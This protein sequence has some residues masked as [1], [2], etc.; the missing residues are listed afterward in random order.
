MVFKKN[1]FSFLLLLIMVVRNHWEEGFWLECEG[2]ALCAWWHRELH[3]HPTALPRAVRAWPPSLQLMPLKL[4]YTPLQSCSYVYK[5]S[6]LW[7]MSSWR[8][9]Q[10][11]PLSKNPSSAMFINFP[12][13]G[14]ALHGIMSS[15]HFQI[16][17]YSV[18][19]R[20]FWKRFTLRSC[21]HWR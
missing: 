20:W 15:F 4:P 11:S 12:G 5:T 7:P 13:V 3:S 19:A 17:T 14:I 21:F 2:S 10:L 18:L 8:L 6:C 9:I 1:F 16:E